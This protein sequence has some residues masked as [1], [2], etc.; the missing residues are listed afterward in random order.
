MQNMAHI[1]EKRAEAGH[2]QQY[3]DWRRGMLLSVRPHVSTEK[4]N[5]LDLLI[6]IIELKEI[7]SVME[8]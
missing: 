4:R 1:F 2:G 6:K 5:F 8:G 3:A 7:I